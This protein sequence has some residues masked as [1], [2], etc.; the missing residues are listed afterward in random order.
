MN[1]D[2]IQLNDMIVPELL[3][4]AEKLAVPEA[5]ALDKQN[6]IYKILDAQALTPLTEKD[7]KPKSKKASPKKVS[8]ET[9]TEDQAPIEKEEAP[10]E[11]KSK[12][13]RKPVAKKE[14]APQNETAAPIQEPAIIAP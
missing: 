5:K 3:D 8:K 13:G 1:Y 2:I 10:T 4:I 7:K 12:R 9:P 11:I 6:L 14:D